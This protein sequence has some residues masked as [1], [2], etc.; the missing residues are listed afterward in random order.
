MTL[1]SPVVGEGMKDKRRTLAL[2]V[3][4]TTTAVVLAAAAL[5]SSWSSYQSA[6]WD[7]DQAASYSR[8]ESLRVRASVAATRAGQAAQVDAGAFSNWLNA[9]MTNKPELEAFYRDHLRPEFRP[10]FEA[11]LKTDPFNDPKAPGTPFVMPEYHSIGLQR[12]EKFN[13]DA[14]A[15][16]NKGERAN[17]ISDAFVAVTVLFASALFFAGIGQAFRSVA[18]RAILLA[19]AS[20]LVGWATVQMSGLPTER[21]DRGGLTRGSDCA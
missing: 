2:H 14:D 7:G 18:S 19:V 13:D 3:I 6:L 12:A 4:E 1:V 11:W 17:T 15:E 8:A 9:K 20:V 21:L 10:T 16:F 5:L